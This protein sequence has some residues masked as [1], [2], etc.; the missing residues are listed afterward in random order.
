MPAE[1]AEAVERVESPPA[2]WIARQ[3]AKREPPRQAAEFHQDAASSAP[4]AA[5][6][7]A[8]QPRPAWQEVRATWLRE[9]PELEAAEPPCT[10]AHRCAAAVA[11]SRCEAIAPA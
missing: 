10:T 7:P 2:P 4:V 9:A 6:P 8:V 3:Q 5:V 11:R 1:E